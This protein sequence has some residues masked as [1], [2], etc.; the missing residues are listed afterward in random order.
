MLL[1]ILLLLRKLSTL[2]IFPCMNAWQIDF[3]KVHL[4]YNYLLLFIIINITSW[5]SLLFDAGL[6]EKC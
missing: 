2:N 5:L 1:F 6:Y 3:F 4:V